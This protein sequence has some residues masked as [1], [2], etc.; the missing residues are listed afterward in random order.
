MIW[1]AIAWDQ[2]FPLVQMTPFPCK[3][4]KG[5]KSIDGKKYAEK[6][7]NGPLAQACRDMAEATGKEILVV[8]DGASPHRSKAAKD[9]RAAQGI[10]SLVHPV[11][12]PDLNPIKTIWQLLKRGLAKRPV[13]PSDQE[14]LWTAIQEVWEEILVAQI[15]QQINQMSVRVQ[16]IR[17]VH[18]WY[19]R[20]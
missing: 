3:Q 15:N 18:G 16:T 17:K 5:S 11:R 19:T 8:E 2:K 9:A 4:P 6:V 12:S 1:G 20:F 10:K 13:I 7:I 14:E